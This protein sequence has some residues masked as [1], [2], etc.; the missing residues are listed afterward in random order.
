MTGRACRPTP[1]NLETPRFQHRAHVVSAL[2]VQA[3]GFGQV[4]PLILCPEDYLQ[5]IDLANLK[6]ALYRIGLL[7][8]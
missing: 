4:L 3:L 6:S 7:H 5:K 2:G 1:P 8:S